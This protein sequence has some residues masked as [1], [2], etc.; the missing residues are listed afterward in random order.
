MSLLIFLVVQV[1][2]VSVK[3]IPSTGPPPVSNLASAAV[4]DPKTGNII[5]IGGQQSKS[6][7]LTS[8]VNIFNIKSK[9]WESAEIISEFSP[10][11]LVNH[12]MYLR[13]DRKILI[14]GRYS[15][16]FLF[17]IDYFSWSTEELKG[18]NI[19][20]VRSYSSTQVVFNETEYFVIFGG[21][22][23]NGFTNDLFL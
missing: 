3:S 10:S 20:G 23:P 11:Y 1:S 21:I 17:D 8:E 16:V 6:D 12:G 22:N 7:L 13:K 14:I 19:G 2:S 15:E 9:S 5:T 18:D 4:Y